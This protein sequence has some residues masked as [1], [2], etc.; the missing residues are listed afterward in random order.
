[1]QNIKDIVWSETYVKDENELTF[2]IRA[3]GPHFVC[4][5]VSE[6]K[7][8]TWG[9]STFNRSYDMAQYLVAVNVRDGWRS[10]EKVAN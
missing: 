2:Q 1:M 5:W 4:E 9:V 7:A 10:A 6:G 8:T 3:W